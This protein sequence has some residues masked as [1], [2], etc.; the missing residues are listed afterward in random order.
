MQARNLH[1]A[2]VEGC[3]LDAEGPQ[4]LL[5]MLSLLYHRI[6]CE[7]SA[8]PLRNHGPFGLLVECHDFLAHVDT[9]VDV[10]FIPTLKVQRKST[11]SVKSHN[12]RTEQA[13]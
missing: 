9:T 7:I 12:W 11:R 5:F 6:S 3:D 13:L 1:E 10:F 4:R 2:K 8:D